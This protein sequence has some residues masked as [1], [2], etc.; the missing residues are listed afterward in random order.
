[1]FSLTADGHQTAVGPPTSVAGNP[2]SLA[3][4]PDGN[5]LA[6]ANGHLDEVSV[7][8]VAA[9]G[10]LTALGSTPLG[11]AA[12]GYAHAVA[13]SPD[14]NLLAVTRG[15]EAGGSVSTF[16]VAADGELTAVDSS[17][18]GS[19]P[20]SVAFRPG[21]GSLA[22]AE[23][24]GVSVFSVAAGG[25]LSP[26]G[27]P[28]PTGDS[29]SVSVAFSP[30]GQT[31]R[32]DVPLGNTVFVFSVS[33]AG[34]LTPVEPATGLL[35][36]FS[37]AVAFSP[38][39]GLLA[40][41]SQQYLWLFRVSAGGVLTAVESATPFLSYGSGSAVAFNPAGTLL[42]LT[43]GGDSTVSVHPLAAP[44]LDVAVTSAPPAM[45]S[46]TTAAFEFEANYPST[47]ECRLDA[48]SF[49]PCA[50][51]ASQ[52]IRGLAEGSHTFAVRATDLLGNVEPSPASR[53]W[54]VDVTAPLDVA[55]VQPA[56]GAADLPASPLFGWSPT[57]DDLTGVD[58]YEL[59]VDAVLS[60]TVPAA[61]CGAT[62]SAT[63]EQPLGD[64]AHSWQVRAVDGA[65]NVAVSGSRPFSVDA[66]PPGSFALSSPADD[67]A[68][69]SRRPA[70]SWQAAVDEGV[71]LSSYD[72]V[73]DDQV[74]ASGLGASATSFTPAGDLAEGVHLWHVV[75][76]D[77]YGNERA[78]DTRRFTVDTTAPVAAF[79]AAP[80]P[81]LAGRSITF[82]AGGS[83]DSGSGIARVEWD[84]D[85]DGAYETDTGAGRTATRSF[86]EPG[87]YA[88]LVRV[89]DRVGLSA[90]GADR[91]ARH[92]GGPDGP[93]RRVDQRPRALY[94][95]AEGHDHGV[96]AAVRQSDARLKR[97]RLR[98]GGDAAAEQ[99]DAVDA[100]FLGCGA[101]QS[102]GVRA[103]P[104]RPDDERDLHRR[105][106][107]GR[108][109]AVGDARARFADP[110]RRAPRLTI[111]ARDRG[112][113]GVASVQ[114]TN[115]RRKPLAKYRRLPREGHARQP[116]R[117]PPAERSQA[118]VR[119]RARPRRQ[120]VGLADGQPH[121]LTLRVRR[122]RRPGDRSRTAVPS[123][124]WR[125][126]AR[127]PAEAAEGP[128]DGGR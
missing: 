54:I 19:D 92:G 112:L 45:T 93:A 28:T 106:H 36:S 57:T 40:A 100:G 62:C 68:T 29:Q 85:G 30:N 64:G 4:S 77:A 49:A 73:L 88:V 70:L 75:A 22:V 23:Q 11:G 67:A 52:R 60:R 55:L 87:T 61:S 65:G 24:G 107:P 9:D 127:P 79:T 72:V 102:P 46:S 13:F 126:A 124:R 120:R 5:L 27:A 6:T 82:D 33:G 50:T 34:A 63:P 59:W 118:A 81:A 123:Q 121:A 76:R 78:S 51:P 7:F 86:T 96:V 3:F 48:A 103:L 58:R 25:A 69:T 26:V 115:N 17:S 53:S 71:G 128:A 89:S 97:R 8:S 83:S 43:I 20:W 32:R 18:T 44:I 84:L 80:N 114:V 116:A 105:H 41:T 119:A 90:T 113:A 56:S 117:L 108:E 21:G 66:A 95:F 2:C 31:A 16:A 37:T 91:P 14:G 74:V 47:L 125:A 38:S 10:V 111:R 99:A 109:P 94:A 15:L 101:F 42:A 110:A 98:G 12:G 1:M 35:D 104:A 122:R 39:G